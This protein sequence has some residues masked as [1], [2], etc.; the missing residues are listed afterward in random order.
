MLD[1]LLAGLLFSLMTWLSFGTVVFGVMIV[2]HVSW[3][4]GARRMAQ[5][6]R[7]R[8]AGMGRA[9]WPTVT[10]IA[11]MAVGWAVPWVLAY[12]VWDMGFL[13]LARAGMGFHYALVTAQRSYRL[14]LWMNPVDFALWLGPAPL[15]LGVAGS[16]WLWRRAADAGRPGGIER[17]GNRSGWNGRRLLVGPGLSGPSAGRR[18]ARWDASGCF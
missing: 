11:L 3:R 2:L 14:W 18:G 13:G 6:S 15:L 5:R 12:L 9:L 17:L 10:G 4:A 16:L 7:D 1:W 8:G